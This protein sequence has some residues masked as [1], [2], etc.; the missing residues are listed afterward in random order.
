MKKL[1]PIE[2]DR[3]RI[4]SILVFTVIPLMINNLILKRFL[5]EKVWK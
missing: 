2:I 4:R 5:E 3:R 1:Y